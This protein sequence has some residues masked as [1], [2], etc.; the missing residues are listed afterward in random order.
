MIEG[1]SL[2]LWGSR[3]PFSSELTP[4]WQIL[5]GAPQT[6][7]MANSNST[8]FKAVSSKSGRFRQAWAIS[9]F[10]FSVPKM[11]IFN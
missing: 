10:N 3:L 4:L 9:L 11:L 2:V 5:S 7:V 1:K 6:M 8:S